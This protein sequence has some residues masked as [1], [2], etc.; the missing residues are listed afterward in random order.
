[1]SVSLPL[2]ERLSSGQIRAVAKRKRTLRQ[3]KTG[4]CAALFRRVDAMLAAVLRFNVLALKIEGCLAAAFAANFDPRTADALAREL[5]AMAADM[6]KTAE[7]CAGFCAR[8]EHNATFK[9][10]RDSAADL[11]ARLA[12]TADVV[13][14]L[15]DMP[16]TE[17]TRSLDH[18]RAQ[19]LAAP[20][21]QQSAMASAGRERF[22]ATVRYARYVRGAQAAPQNVLTNKN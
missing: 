22:A 12:R 18:V 11:H 16:R 7:I 1:M 13:A 3:Y 6:K 4:P 21:T 5:R 15:R 10:W 8:F 2:L 20:G 19:F 17:P 9:Q 14:R